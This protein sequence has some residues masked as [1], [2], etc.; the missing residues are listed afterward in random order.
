[1]RTVS[2]ESPAPAPE[3]RLGTLAEGGLAPAIMAIVERGVTRRPALAAALRAEIELALQEQCPVRV[4]FGER[5]VLV[6]DGQAAAPDVRVEGTL[7]DLV[8]L[9]VAPQ[10]GGMPV[11]IQARGRSAFGMMALGRVRFRGRFGLAR[12]FLAIIRI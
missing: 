2:V 11:P 7:T 4:V 1:M 3:V 10:W 5:L 9:M 6:E 12:R 8:S